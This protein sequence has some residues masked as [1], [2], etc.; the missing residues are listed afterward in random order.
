ML[1]PTF[2]PEKNSVSFEVVE[3]VRDLRK[4]SQFIVDDS[5]L[6]GYAK[7]LNPFTSLVYFS[8][9]RHADRDQRCFPGLNK[10]AEEFSIHRNSVIAGIKEL[11]SW[12]IIRIDRRKGK[13]NVYVLLD[14]E[15]WKNPGIGS[16]DN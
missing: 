11:E 10:I 6:N 13:V 4:K 1:R 2:N 14:K 5:Y 8:L 9:C 16:G 7:E 12:N 3:E 15:A